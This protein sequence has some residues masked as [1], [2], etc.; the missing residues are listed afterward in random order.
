MK[1]IHKDNWHTI[2]NESGHYFLKLDKE[3]ISSATPVVVDM[4]T[5]TFIRGDTKQKCNVLDYC[6]ESNWQKWVWAS[7]GQKAIVIEIPPSIKKEKIAKAIIDI[8]IFFG[9]IN[10]RDDYFTKQITEGFF[11]TETI[12]CVHK[13]LDEKNVPGSI[14]NKDLSVIGRIMWLIN[15]I[16]KEGKENA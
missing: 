13:W 4:V 14:D 1:R 12:E 6:S 11:A 16:E 2:P 7:R 5:G 10:W 9:I 15:H 3:D 8:L